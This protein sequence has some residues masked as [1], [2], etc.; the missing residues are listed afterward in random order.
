MER[1]INRVRTFVDQTCDFANS[2][3]RDPIELVTFSVL[4]KINT[5]LRERKHHRK[6]VLQFIQFK[7]PLLG[8]FHIRVYCFLYI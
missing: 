4:L 1:N 6:T 2:K 8:N 7:T 5:A 3:E